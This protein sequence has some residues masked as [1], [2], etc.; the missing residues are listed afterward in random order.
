[1]Q[2]SIEVIGRQKQKTLGMEKAK[3]TM[4]YF[5]VLLINLHL[6]SNPSEEDNQ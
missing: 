1:M 4:I 2:R 3:V 6:A 5:Q